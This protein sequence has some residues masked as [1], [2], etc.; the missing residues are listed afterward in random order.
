MKKA[1]GEGSKADRLA[2]IR[3]ACRLGEEETRRQLRGA[4]RSWV[5]NSKDIS[6]ES[7]KGT[8]HLTH[9]ALRRG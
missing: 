6:T 9:H 1:I 3:E 2:Q 4:H 5:I 8:G 7:E